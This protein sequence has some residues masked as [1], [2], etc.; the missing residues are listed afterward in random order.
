VTF[1]PGYFPSHVRIGAISIVVR[2]PGD[3]TNLVEVAPHTPLPLLAEVW[4]FASALLSSSQCP[5]LRR[6]RVVLTVVGN[7]LVVLDRLYTENASVKRRS[8][9]GESNRVCNRSSKVE[10]TI[11]PVV[12]QALGPSGCRKYHRS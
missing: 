12:D 10:L 11:V 8:N 9:R 7:L 6:R 5:P 4:K 3:I 2:S 1:L